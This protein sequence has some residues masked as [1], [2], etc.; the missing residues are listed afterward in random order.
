[1]ALTPEDEKNFSDL[2]AH[3]GRA[4]SH[5]RDFE[6]GLKK[7]LELIRRIKENYKKVT[8]QKDSISLA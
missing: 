2:S 8:E 5:H 6:N 3:I 7:S 1:M 4:L